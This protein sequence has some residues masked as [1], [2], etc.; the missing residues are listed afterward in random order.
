MATSALSR[1]FADTRA[2]NVR[3]WLT[4]SLLK[5]AVRAAAEEAVRMGQDA[6]GVKGQLLE[7]HEALLW[8]VGALVTGEASDAGTKASKEDV[9]RALVKCGQ[10]ALA[11]RYEI[12]AE[13]RR[14]IAHWDRSIFNTVRTNLR[15]AAKQCSEGK[16]TATAS[17]GEEFAD[18]VVDGAAGQPL[19]HS[20]AS[21]S[22]CTSGL[23]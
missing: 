21:T 11:K 4:E 7:E 20:D 23:R 18:S 3:A 14:A 19:S 2:L 16:T 13:G 22:T 17:G 5:D 12:A 9:R 6:S 8:D 10:P 15:A 1:V